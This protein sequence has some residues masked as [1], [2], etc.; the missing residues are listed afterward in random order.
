ME[1]QFDPHSHGGEFG[2]SRYIQALLGIA[3]FYQASDIHIEPDSLGT[4][5]RLRIDGQ[6]RLVSVVPASHSANLITKLK[7]M[8]ALDIAESRLPQDGRIKA[9]VSKQQLECRVSTCPTLNGEQM[10]S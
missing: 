9:V 8:S 1:L 6:L 5:I 3:I 7:V 2:L 4:R 10:V